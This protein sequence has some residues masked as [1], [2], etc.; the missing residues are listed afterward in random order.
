MKNQKEIEDRIEDINNA[1]ED[2][3]GR[4]NTEELGELNI[5]LET[6]EW[7]INGEWK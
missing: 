7:V 3:I 6:L 1:I 2:L 4:D 5:K